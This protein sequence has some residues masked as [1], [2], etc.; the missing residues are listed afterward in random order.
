MVVVTVAPL[1]LLLL[2]LLVL[3]LLRRRRRAHAV[4]ATAAAGGAAGHARGVKDAQHRVKA[5]LGRVA[6]L[7]VDAVAEVLFCCEEVQGS[8]GGVAAGHC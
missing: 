8:G 2:L 5:R 4:A 7:A 6:L 3:L 1:A